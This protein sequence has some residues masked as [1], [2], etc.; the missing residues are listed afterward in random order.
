MF[1]ERFVVPVTDDIFLIASQ[2]QLGENNGVDAFFAT[3][4]VVAFG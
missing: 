2:V 1:L 4:A 3:T